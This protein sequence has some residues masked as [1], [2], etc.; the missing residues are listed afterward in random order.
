MEETPR[1]VTLHYM[2]VELDKG[3]IIAQEIIDDGNNETLASSYNNLDRAAKALF[4]KAFKHYQFWPLLKK[5]C[6]G[7][8]TYHS[9]KDGIE[10]KKYIDTYD[11]SLSE[12]RARLINP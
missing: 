12:F 2:D 6:L 3:Y 7:R 5:Q 1:G 11:I 4:K 8:G 10:V 9:L